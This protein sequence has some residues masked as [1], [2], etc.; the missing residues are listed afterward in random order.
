MVRSTTP[1]AT[2]VR[3]APSRRGWMRSTLISSHQRPSRLAADGVVRWQLSDGRSRRC[4]V[5]IQPRRC[6][7]VSVCSMVSGYGMERCRA[8]SD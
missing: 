7:S 1:V 4:T 6:R 8:Q 2:S 3:R 5:D